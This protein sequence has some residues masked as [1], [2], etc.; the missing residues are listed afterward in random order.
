MTGKNNKKIAD[1]TG[2]INVKTGS[3]IKGNPKLIIPFSK[4]PVTRAKSI[5][6]MVKNSNSLNI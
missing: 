4:P 2:N 1:F 6:N 5:I 3:A